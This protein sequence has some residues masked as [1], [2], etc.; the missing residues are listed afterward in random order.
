[1]DEGLDG[2]F[3]EVHVDVGFSAYAH[4]HPLQPI[5]QHQTFSQHV[6]KK[7]EDRNKARNKWNNKY[8]TWKVERNT[9]IMYE[10]MTRIQNFVNEAICLHPV[11]WYLNSAGL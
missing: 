9:L 10:N 7:D 8:K 4:I 11:R 6:L 5:L 3:A 2:R 1:M